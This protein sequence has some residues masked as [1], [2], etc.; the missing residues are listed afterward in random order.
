MIH[1]ILNVLD[2]VEE[3]MQK[4]GQVAGQDEY[5]QGNNASLGPHIHA[6]FSPGFLGR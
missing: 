1:G 5:S 6:T 3:R 4:G 2:I